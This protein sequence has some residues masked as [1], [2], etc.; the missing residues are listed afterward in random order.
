[1]TLEVLADVALGLEQMRQLGRGTDRATEGPADRAEA[2]WPYDA[3][4]KPIRIP[5]QATSLS[6][7]VQPS[8]VRRP[9]ERNAEENTETMEMKSMIV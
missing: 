3:K 7:V 8:R 9:R 2:T 5:T 1:M 6:W 4:R